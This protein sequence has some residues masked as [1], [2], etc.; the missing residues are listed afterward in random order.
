MNTEIKVA[1]YVEV[2]CPHSTFRG[3]RGRVVGVTASK[4]GI[5]YTVG[6]GERACGGFHEA[7]LKVVER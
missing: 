3:Q 1:L 2:I 5:R 6:F 7:D 4:V